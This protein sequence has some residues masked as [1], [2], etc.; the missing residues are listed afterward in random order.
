[1]KTLVAVASLL[2]MLVPGVAFAGASTDAALGLGAFAVFN[3]IISG[4]GIFGAF[5]PAPGL[6]VVAPPVQER[7]VVR[8]YHPVYVQPPVYYAHPPVHYYASPRRVV[9]ISERGW[10]PPGPAKRGHY[11]H[12]GYG[13]EES[14]H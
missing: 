7:V 10:S 5:H 2:A 8:E 1:M 14:L 13:R 3:Q 6:V 9:V 12:S 4:T 11:G